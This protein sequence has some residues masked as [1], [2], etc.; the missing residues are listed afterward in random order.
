MTTEQTIFETPNQEV[1]PQPVVV[2]QPALPP[3]VVEYVGEGKKYKSVED[4]LKSV[5][6]AQSH[7]QTLEE[8]LAAAEAEL[9][10]RRTAEELLEDIKQGVQQPGTTIPKVDLSTDAVSE[11][12][13]TALQ[14]EKIAEKQRNNVNSVAENFIST[15]GDK[16]KA[17]EAYEKIAQENGLTV[18]QLNNLAATSP[19]AV[20]KLAGITRGAAPVAK[21]TGSINPLAIT[22]PKTQEQPSIRLKLGAT[23]KDIMASWEAAKQKV[24]SQQ[25]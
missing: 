12:V 9:A 24:V 13:R 6:H 18:G 5:P 17:Q 10:K 4:A 3:E 8:K 15:F 1:S 20:L 19:D 7:I 22:Q 21:T 14:Q 25:S 16:A 2:Q 11:I 23:T